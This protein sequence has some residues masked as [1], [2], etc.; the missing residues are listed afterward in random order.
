MADSKEEGL[1][2]RA[3]NALT[4]LF[5]GDAAALGLHWIYDQADIL[6][7]IGDGKPEF[8]DPKTHSKW[9]REVVLGDLSHHGDDARV[10]LASVVESKGIDAANYQKHF[11]EYFGS[12]SYK[13]YL[14]HAPSEFVE[15][16]KPVDDAQSS[17]LTR[18]A[19][20]AVLTLMKS[21]AEAEEAALKALR[22]IHKSGDADV[23]A[24]AGTLAIRA[25]LK[26]PGKPIG[27]SLETVKSHKTTVAGFAPTVKT[28]FTN[29]L[30]KSSLSNQ[31]FTKAVGAS[32]PSMFTLP[33]GLHAAA[34]DGSYEEV[35][36]DIILSGGDSCGR[37][38]VAGA[39]AGAT[40]GTPAAWFDKVLA[41]DEIK[42]NIEA[43]LD[44]AGL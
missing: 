24:L 17:A 25:V 34:K 9:H 23:T 33:T 14:D 27:T 42:T 29:L 7:R 32:C 41:K 28:L 11:L 37:I 36:R 30:G 13:K 8:L 6:S 39:V 22:V 19:V 10:F 16:K 18:C 21:D 43:L 35:I 40:F 20:V 1:R 44:L 26:N 2:E 5:A 3:Y 4:G 31:A 12:P 15:G 38:M